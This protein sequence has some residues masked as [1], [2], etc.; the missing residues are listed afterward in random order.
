MTSLD[1]RLAR[2]AARADARRRLLGGGSLL[3]TVEAG[4]ATLD[5][6]AVYFEKEILAHKNAVLARTGDI[7]AHLKGGSWFPDAAYSLS[8]F[9]PDND[10][11]GRVVEA[12]EHLKLM[13]TSSLESCRSRMPNRAAVETWCTPEYRA[14]AAV[15]LLALDGTNRGMNLRQEAY[16]VEDG[17][18]VLRQ[19][20]PAPAGDET[21]QVA[22]E[23]VGRFLRN[24]SRHP[25]FNH[26]PREWSDQVRSGQPPP[27]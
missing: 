22:D 25:D 27:N 11:P 20:V 19:L 3:E 2:A 21:R 15:T 4:T 10:L 23:H 6:Y 7:F 8:G 24:V 14:V 16:L 12:L 5:G 1:A 13:A 9:P 17:R 26:R 18:W